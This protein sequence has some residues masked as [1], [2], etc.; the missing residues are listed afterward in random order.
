MEREQELHDLA[1]H[2]GDLAQRIRPDWGSGA[3]GGGFQTR[4][5]VDLQ[6]RAPLLRDLAGAD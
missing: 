5:N 6:Y 1:Q 4:V 2:A 3:P